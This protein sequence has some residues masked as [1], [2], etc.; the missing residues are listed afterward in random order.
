MLFTNEC[1]SL[2]GSADR[3]ILHTRCHSLELFCLLNCYVS[4]LHFGLELG[5]DCYIVCRLRSRFGAMK[6]MTQSHGSNANTLPSL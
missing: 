6:G 5:S 1:D 3:S 4:P 2:D